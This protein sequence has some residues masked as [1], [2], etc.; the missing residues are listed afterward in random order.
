[1]TFTIVG[2]DHRTA[3]L[4]AAVGTGGPL[5]SSCRLH[6][7]PGAGLIATQGPARH[8][9]ALDGVELLQQGLSPHEVLRQLLEPE[10]Q[11]HR[12]QILILD[13][14]GR[15]GACSGRKCAPVYGHT[16]GTDHVA[17]GD[18]MPSTSVVGAMSL[19][20]ERSEGDPLWER[21]LLALESGERAGGDRRGVRSARLLVYGGGPEPIIDLRAEQR[22]R[23]TVELRRLLARSW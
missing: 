23:P 12:R 4:G 21:L 19:S 15:P 11:R 8:E 17:G 13:A 16:E 9:L 22:A 2:R 6:G 7:S 18:F 10:R 5:A 3:M 20:F 1:M 14:L